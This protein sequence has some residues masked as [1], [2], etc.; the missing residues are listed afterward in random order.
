[1]KNFYKL[2]A[3]G[4]AG[5]GDGGGAGGGEKMTYGTFTFSTFPGSQTHQIAHGL[6][7]RPKSFAI[8]LPMESGA[9]PALAAVFGVYKR[10]GSSSCE[11]RVF[12][13]NVSSSDDT[14]SHAIFMNSQLKDT[15]GITCDAEHITIDLTAK[16]LYLINA[17][18]YYWV[19]FSEEALA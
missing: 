8:Y 15:W 12:Y 14:A 18:T 1:M 6:N 5:G 9:K 13:G 17:K 3:L 7:S 2:L 10:A 16:N 19:A 4:G 11:G